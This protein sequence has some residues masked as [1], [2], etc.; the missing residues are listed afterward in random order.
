[1][2][3]HVKL[4]PENL[5]NLDIR[6]TPREEMELYQLDTFRYEYP[7]KEI[8]VEFEMPE[9]TA[10]CPF[11]DFP[12]FAVIKLK[13][14][15]NERCIELKSLKLYI[16]SFRNV[17]VFHEHVINMIMEDFV[18]A[19]D[20]LRVEIEGDFHVRGNIKTVVRANYTKKI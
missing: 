13:Y 8:W 14:V 10:I 18:N 2:S 12:D 15:P 6:S 1:M 3:D 9:F 19:C 17:K 11:S 7:G 16:N 5:Q 20:P 4:Q